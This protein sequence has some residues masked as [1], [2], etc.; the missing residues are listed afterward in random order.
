MRW[1][2]VFAALLA[3]SGC[4][5]SE[6]FV[7]E[8]ARESAKSAV[9]EVLTTSFP[10][11]PKR[12]VTPFTDCVIDAASSSEIVQFARAAIVGVDAQT[13]TLTQNILSR[14]A[15]TTCIVKSGVSA[16]VV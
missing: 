8:I 9:S 3:L 2:G 13:V 14:P 10:A 12:A 11:V 4:A 6:Q 16:L 7:D 1:R 5:A 15:T